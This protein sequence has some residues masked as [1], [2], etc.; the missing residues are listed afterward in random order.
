MSSESLACRGV[1]GH[2]SPR[3]AGFL[4]ACHDMRLAASE[5]AAMVKIAASLSVDFAIDA[6]RV[7]AGDAAGA[8]TQPGYAPFGTSKSGPHPPSTKQPLTTQPSTTQPSTKQPSP[9]KPSGKPEPPSVA[10]KIYMGPML[11]MQVFD[12]AKAPFTP[13]SPQHE[14]TPWI[15]YL[16]EGHYGHRLNDPKWAPHF[17][18]EQRQRAFYNS[19]LEGFRIATEPAFRANTRAMQAL[20]AKMNP[21]AMAW[22]Y[23]YNPQIYNP[24]SSDAAIRG[25]ADTAASVVPLVAWS[26]GTLPVAIAS[27]TADVLYNRARQSMERTPYVPDQPITTAQQYADYAAQSAQHGRDIVPLVVN[28]A[29]F[30]TPEELDK[31]VS[32]ERAAQ[33]IVQDIHTNLKNSNPDEVSRAVN[34]AISGQL[35]TTAEDKLRAQGVPENRILD[36]WHSLDTGQRVA[37]VLGVPLGAL[38]LLQAVAG[39]GGT[40]GWLLAALGLGA[41]GSATG[42]FG[43][44]AK[45]VVSQLLGAPGEFFFGQPKQDASAAGELGA[46]EPGAGKPGAPAPNGAVT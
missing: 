5:I 24:G 16:P 31:I 34:T 9:F 27:S 7:K 44:T 45:D 22:E 28:P 6:Q 35:T 2:L 42:L 23:Y 25:I 21:D 14:L 36:F 30:A 1:D 43:Q 10:P 32:D 38:G 29:D 37:V 15:Q 33:G 41:A 17:T 46:G 40:L 19:A 3:F 13:S 18:P 39:E 8:P 26:S 4:K 12:P 11:P 20:E